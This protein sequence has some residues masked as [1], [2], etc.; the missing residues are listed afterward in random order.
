VFFYNYLSKDLINQV[1][2]HMEELLRE[3]SD[4]IGPSFLPS[5]PSSASSPSSHTGSYPSSISYHSPI[6]ESETETKPLL[7][8]SM[9]APLSSNTP[10]PSDAPPPNALQ[11]FG[12]SI[13]DFDNR[14][15]I[16]Q[17][18]TTGASNAAS[19][20][21]EFSEKYQVKDKVFNLFCKYFW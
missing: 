5:S 4:G 21:K 7:S 13:K 15:Q 12:K 8:F 11:S 6:M 20:I 1:T 9:S 18:I 2:K 19:S 14:H 10:P 16:S 3:I 17:T